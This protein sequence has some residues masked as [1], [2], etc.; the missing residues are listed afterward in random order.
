MLPNILVVVSVVSVVLGVIFKVGNIYIFG[1]VNAK[2][3]LELTYVCIAFA[4]ALFLMQ[5]RDKIKS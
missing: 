1:V 3:F 5:I 4:I 2:N